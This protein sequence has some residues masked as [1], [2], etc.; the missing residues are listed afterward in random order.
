MVVNIRLEIYERCSR[1][2]SK[3]VGSR[4]GQIV[5]LNEVVN[6]DFDSFLW[7]RVG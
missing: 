5:G 6:S 3:Q 2:G 1:R 7:E 4:G